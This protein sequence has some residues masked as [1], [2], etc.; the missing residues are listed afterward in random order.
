[1]SI[2][3]IEI[4]LPGFLLLS[5]TADVRTERPLGSGGSG[6]IFRGILLN[7][8]VKKKNN[9]NAEVVVKRI[10][11]LFLPA[12]LSFFLL[13]IYLKSGFHKVGAFP[14]M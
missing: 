10:R 5:S 8:D 6:D 4:S 14:Q 2:S 12:F 13:F 1:M 11:G 7:P 3:A 9:G